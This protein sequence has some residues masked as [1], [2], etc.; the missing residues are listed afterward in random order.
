MA[1]G[2]LTSNLMQALAVAPDGTVYAG[3]AA[4]L[5]IRSTAG[6]WRTL[7]QTDGLPDD[8]VTS[9]VREA[10]G[11]LWIGTPEGAAVL[12]PDGRLTVYRP[13]DGGL[14]PGTIGAMAVDAGGAPWL[15]SQGAGIAILDAAWRTDR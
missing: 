7:D 12:A 6:L 14:L 1:T 15:A 9:L 8:S 11:R 10:D 3:T 4:G 2:A 13:Q 5:A